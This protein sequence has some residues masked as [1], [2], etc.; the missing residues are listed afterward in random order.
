MTR[1]IKDDKTSYIESLYAVE[2]EILHETR[3]SINEYLQKIQISPLEGKIIHVLLNMVKAKKVLEIGTLAGYSAIWIARALP[4]DGQLTC[5]EKSEENYKI[6]L[7]NLQNA[8]PDGKVKLINADAKEL[9]PTLN[10][11]FDAVFIDADKTS[12]PFYLEQTYRLLNQGG[13]II[14]DNTL[15]FGKVYNKSSEEMVIAMQE[16]NQK[17]S[18]PDR[19]ISIILP[20]NE[21][22][23]I[24]IK[25]A[26][27]K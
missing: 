19:F 21:G 8:V 14:A 11:K 23:T 18:D 22:L 5:I 2:D 17:I 26:A 4:K 24:A 12:Y 6:A 20:T 25:R 3:V 13:L 7:A 10:E 1:N 15:L 9:L 16:F 27:S